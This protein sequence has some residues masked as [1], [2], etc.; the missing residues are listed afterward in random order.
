[1]ADGKNVPALQILHSNLAEFFGQFLSK[2]N[3]EMKCGLGCSQ[4]CTAGLTVFP[5]EAQLILDWF[6]R[7]SEY[8]REALKVQWRGK[9]GEKQTS[10]FKRCTFLIENA[11]SIYPVRPVLCR[12]QGLPMKV[13][14]GDNEDGGKD[15]AL[16]LCE[17]NFPDES[18]LPS[19]EEWLDL[20]RVNVLLSIAEKFAKN[21][22]M[23]ATLKSL[24]DADSGRISL[25]A[26][27]EYL[28][29]N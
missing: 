8:E 16:S 20:E 29:Q 6:S 25:S 22:T 10:D 14:A 23:S 4:C 12:A 3:A 17:L 24:A 18:K 7:L 5:V 9:S 28:L 2:Y 13:L 21:S 11:C 26:I 19:V 15:Y 1:M 27:R